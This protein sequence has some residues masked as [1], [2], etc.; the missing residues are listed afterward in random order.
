MLC[1]DDRISQRTLYA[2][3]SDLVRGWFSFES[4]IWYYAYFRLELY[5]GVVFGSFPGMLPAIDRGIA[6]RRAGARKTNNK[7]G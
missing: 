2:T 5:A 1:T 4:W 6:R 7:F 3:R